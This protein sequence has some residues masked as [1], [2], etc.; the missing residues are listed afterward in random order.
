MKC[1]QGEINT[2]SKYIDVIIEKI[3]YIFIEKKSIIESDLEIRI[4]NI[5]Y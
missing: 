2:K 3:H 4:K 5:I 1:E